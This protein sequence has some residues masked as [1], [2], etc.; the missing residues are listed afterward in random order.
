VG[1]GRRKGERGMVYD[2]WDPRH[3]GWMCTE[4]IDIEE[5]ISLIRRE[6]SF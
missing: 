6:Y 3:R 5:R 2:M 1:R 4:E